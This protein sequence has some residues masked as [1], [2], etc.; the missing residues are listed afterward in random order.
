MT[1]LT[2]NRNTTR[3]QSFTYDPLNRLATAK[4]TSTTG[5]TCWDEVF[6]TP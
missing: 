5:A 3:S 2:G 4:V 1:A 6:G